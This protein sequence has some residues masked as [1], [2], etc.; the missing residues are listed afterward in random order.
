MENSNAAV[1]PKSCGKCGNTI[2]LRE[3]TKALV[4]TAILDVVKADFVE[5]CEHYEE[6]AENSGQ[7]SLKRC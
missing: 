6:R 4:C 3:E 1:A 5:V 2:R 7:S